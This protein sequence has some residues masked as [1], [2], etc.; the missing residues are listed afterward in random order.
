LTQATWDDLFATV[1][2]VG[3][4][5]TMLSTDLGQ[6]GRARPVAGMAEGIAR[7]LD[8]GFAPDALRAA[9]SDRAQQVIG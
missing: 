1:H 6:Q 5:S 3:L 7:L 2:A 8:A 9:F 4:G